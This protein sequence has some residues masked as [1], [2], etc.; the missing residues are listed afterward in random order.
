MCSEVT[1][2]DLGDTVLELLERS[3][4]LLSVGIG[5]GIGGVLLVFSWLLLLLRSW[6]VLL[7]GG[8]LL[9]VSVSAVLLSGF[10]VGGVFSLLSRL[11]GAF[12]TSSGGRFTRLS[13]G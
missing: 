2:E 7:L 13:G 8:S 11:D 4:L 3:L 1:L 12:G 9:S 10:L 5:G 6:L